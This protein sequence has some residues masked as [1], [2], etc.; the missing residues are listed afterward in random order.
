MIKIMFVCHGNICRSPMAEFI[1]K[2]IV[3]DAGYSDDFYIVSCATSIE[4][5]GNPVYPPAKTELAKHGV[6]C[7]GKTAVQLQKADYDK[8]D[9]LIG[10]D[11]ANIRNMNRIFGGDKDGKICK[12]LAFADRDD[13]VFDP[14]YSRDFSKAYSDIEE[15][16]K[17]LF[18][19][20]VDKFE[21][22]SDVRTFRVASPICIVLYG[23]PSKEDNINPNLKAITD[24]F[25][26]YID[27]VYTEKLENFFLEQK[28]G[29]GDIWVI[30]D[31]KSNC[32]VFDL[33]REPCDQMDVISFGVICKNE[34]RDRIYALMKA[35]KEET[36]RKLCFSF[37]DMTERKV[38]LSAVIA[39]E[40]KCSMGN[41]TQKIRYVG[42]FDDFCKQNNI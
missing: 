24:I 16:C 33:Y 4:E 34:H 27:N 39:G 8:Y 1:M 40:D 29:E 31:H 36:Q 15:G 25:G 12:L 32:L 17:G 37:Y 9:Y 5:L 35:M 3:S 14:W 7:A 2:K 11:A 6:G 20:L 13:D 26:I 22:K 41:I 42:S 38:W 18:A 30:G 28:S 10:M 19:M 23:H 21:L